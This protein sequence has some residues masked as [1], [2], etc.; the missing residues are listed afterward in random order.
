[1]KLPTTERVFLTG[2]FAGLYSKHVCVVADAT[3]EE[4]L[5]VCRADPSERLPGLTPFQWTRVIRT[6][7]D[8]EELGLTVRS[9]TTGRP[10]R[11]KQAGL[12]GPCEL[13]PGRIHIVVR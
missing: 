10:L 1:M 2:S 12:P 5:A 7:K 3:D 8:I 4:I 13:I 9:A 11:N 6:Q